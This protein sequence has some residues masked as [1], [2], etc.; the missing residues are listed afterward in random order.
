MRGS[1]FFAMLFSKRMEQPK[2]YKAKVVK[3]LPR[4][5]AMLDNGVAVDAHPD[6]KVGVEVFVLQT[7]RN[8]IA[9]RH[10]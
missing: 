8:P 2:P 9:V 7:A 3:L 6:W 4:K 1:D 5:I 10:Q